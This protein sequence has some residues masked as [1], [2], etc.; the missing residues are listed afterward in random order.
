MTRKPL[1]WIGYLAAGFVLL[2]LLAVGVVVWKVDAAA[3][4]GL[5]TSATASLGQPTTTDSVHVSLLNGNIGVHELEVSNLQGYQSPSIIRVGKVRTSVAYASL[6]TDTL[7]V[8][9]VEID[10]LVLNIEQKGLV[11]N[12]SEWMRRLK[13]SGTGSPPPPQP[14]DKHGK[15]LQIDR[16]VVRNIVAHVQLL[17]IGGQASRVKVEVPEIV[18]EEVT[19]ERTKAVVVGEL[20]R[21][22]LPAIVAAVAKGGQGVLPTDLAGDLTQS[23]AAAVSELGAEAGKLLE[24]VTQ[25]P[26]GGLLK[27]PEALGDKLKEGAESI[28]GG[29]KKK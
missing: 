4:Y 7:R 16:V 27:A 17:P 8:P 28:F 29:E 13:K 5:E 1:K 19:P 25:D 11:N 14:S 20:I 12:I 15:K 10:G 9:E 3:K 22:I 21:R 24:Q 2:C 26:I 23:A 6:W 18:M